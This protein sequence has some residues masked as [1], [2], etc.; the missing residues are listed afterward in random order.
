MARKK[1]AAAIRLSMGTSGEGVWLYRFTLSNYRLFVVVH[2]LL[3]VEGRRRRA[4]R[5]GSRRSTG[6]CRGADGGAVPAPRDRWPSQSPD[7]GQPPA[8]PGGA[9]VPRKI[10]RAVGV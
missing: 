4:G 9:I 8:L 3:Q 6:D 1:A 7:R 2:G 5:L 10:V